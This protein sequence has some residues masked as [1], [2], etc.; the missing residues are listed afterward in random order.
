MS[1]AV[2][3][4][5]EMMRRLL[6]ALA[7]VFFAVGP[8]KAAEAPRDTIVRFY[9]VLQDVMKN[10]KQLGFQGREEKLAPVIDSVF[11]MPEMT[12]LTL[13]AAGKSLAPE[14]VTALTDAFRRYTVASYA[15]NFDDFNGEK[16]AVGETR[17]APNGALVV[18][19]KLT[20][21]GGAPAVSLDYVMRENDGRWGIVDILMDG[22]VSQVAM[23]RSE[24]VSLLRREGFDTLLKTIEGKTKALGT[25]G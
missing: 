13:G 18:L 25:K 8:V 24:F 23:R 22:S 1:G 19:S 10:G 6:F 11:N 21:S 7:L 12:R 2:V 9:D 14:Q 5:H 3:K 4:G 20:P 17:P 16:F 15:D